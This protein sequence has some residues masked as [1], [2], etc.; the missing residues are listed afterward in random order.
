M[1]LWFAFSAVAVF[2]HYYALA[3]PLAQALW[4]IGRKIRHRATPLRPWISGW[5]ALALPFLL[6]LWYHRQVW[7]NQTDRRFAEWDV[8]ALLEI[9][10]RT[11][12]AYGAGTTLHPHQTVWAW[13]IVALALIG[14]VALVWHGRHAPLLLTATAT[15]IGLAWALTPLLPFFWE[16][17]LFGSLPPFLVLAGAGVAAPWLRGDIGRKQS[18]AAA[19]KAALWSLAGTTLVVTAATLS[20]HN[21]YRDPAF[22]KGGYGRLMQAIGSQAQPGD[23]ILL[24]GPL[25]ASL[26]DYYRP[27]A[28]PWAMLPRDRLLTDADALAAV[29]EAAAGHRR[30]W[31]VESGNPAEY[32]P[33]GRA[34][35]ALARLGGF[36]RKLEQPGVTG[37]L[38]VLESA[39]SPLTPLTA[40]VGDQI[41]LRGY[42]V[43]ADFLLPADTLLVTLTWEALA[44]PLRDYTVFVHLLAADGSLIAQADGQPV[45]GNRPTSGWQPGETIRD[46]YA[47]PLPETL[48]GGAATLVAGLYTW[49]ELARLPVWQEGGAES[50]DAIL[51]HT[52]TLEPQ[53]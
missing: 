11:L 41:A 20:L 14:A 29:G 45:G 3:I 37:W 25:Q 21:H 22:V 24:N 34:R 18:F 5:I 52:L 53:P 26:F 43:S 39:D 33:D 35:G 7:S 46:R 17:Y 27:M 32:D 6:Y 48:P 47:L 38:F 50:A 4:L 16:R 30:A 15:G 12:T 42:T 23:V 49:P 10:R 44:P 28:L 40:T 36:T 51:L 31:L 19:W 2:S 13:A 9:G 1:V 8:A